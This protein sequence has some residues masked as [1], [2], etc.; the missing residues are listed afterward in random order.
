MQDLPPFFAGDLID[1]LVRVY[2][3]FPQKDGDHALWQ[4]IAERI[5]EIFVRVRL[6]VPQQTGLQ[7]FIGQGRLEVDPQFVLPFLQFMQVG[8]RAEND[9]SGDSE[10]S[11]EHFPEVGVDGLPR[12]DIDD[13]HRDVAQGQPLHV[14][15]GRVVGRHRDEGRDDLGDR[16]PHFLRHPVAVAGRAG[17]GV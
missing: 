1:F 10:V 6:E 5:A 13:R 2:P 16:V 3:G 11:K 15:A 17:P 4:Q 7:L 12:F 14:G 9:R 8:T